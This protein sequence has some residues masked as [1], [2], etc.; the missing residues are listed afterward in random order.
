MCVCLF[1]TQGELHYCEKQV[2]GGLENHSP[3]FKR[4]FFSGGGGGYCQEGGYN[5]GGMA[6]FVRRG[7]FL[8]TGVFR[9][10]R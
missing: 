4:S 6:A 3:S 10:L 1:G 2:K 7:V 5:E 9:A 8:G